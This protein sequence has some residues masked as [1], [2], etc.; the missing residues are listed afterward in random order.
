MTINAQRA[1]G[2]ALALLAPIGVLISYLAAYG[3]LPDPLPVHWNIRGAVNNTAST[4]GF[5]VTTLVISAVLAAGVAAAI[6]LSHSPMA[7]RMLASLLAFG[8]WL[9]TVVCVVTLAASAGAT[10]AQDVSMPWYAIVAVVVLPMVLAAGMWALLPGRWESPRITPASSSMHLAPGDKVVWIGHQY[11]I[12][13]RLLACVLAGVG[14][15]LLWVQPA[16]SIPLFVVAV[17]LAMVSELAVRIDQQGVHTLWGPFGWPHPRIALVDI[18]SAHAEQ[19]EPAAWGGWGY[20]VSSRG[21]AAVIR[22]GPGL[23][24]ERTDKPTYAVTVPNADRAADVLGAL[25][26]RQRAG[27]AKA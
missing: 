27:N 24:I 2:T 12:W 8:A 18:T 20:R 1:V 4:T 16:M 23:V 21:V 15:V 5:F 11:S 17:A 14:A 7:G 22:R 9:V 13:M 3:S 6:W 19:I 25:L 10:R 26:A